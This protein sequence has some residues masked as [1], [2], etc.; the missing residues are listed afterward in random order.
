M[1]VKV[2]TFKPKNV[3][4]TVVAIEA[5]IFTCKVIHQVVDMQLRAARTDASQE[6]QAL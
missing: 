1:S 4:F 3:F 5:A 2:I 6:S